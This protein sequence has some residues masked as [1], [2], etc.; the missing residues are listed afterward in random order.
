MD[1]TFYFVT[2]LYL[3]NVKAENIRINAHV[4]TTVHYPH[5]KTTLKNIKTVS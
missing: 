4:Y 2:L 1:I 3:E 5:I